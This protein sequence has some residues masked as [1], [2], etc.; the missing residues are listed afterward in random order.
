MKTLEAKK[1]SLIAIL[2]AA[3]M[4]FCVFAVAIPADNTIAAD[5]ETSEDE[6]SGITID[7][8][9]LDM[10]KLTGLYAVS[11]IET[12]LESYSYDTEEDKV[13][14][15]DADTDVSDIVSTIASENAE[16]LV[17]RNGVKVTFDVDDDEA[18]TEHNTIEIGT[19]VIENGATF[20]ASAL[21]SGTGDLGNLGIIKTK[22]VAIDGVVIAHLDSLMI[23]KTV[24]IST[25][26]DAT[27]A[28]RL[29]ITF[30]VPDQDGGLTFSSTVTGET[31]ADA[32]E[33]NLTI[34]GE[35]DHDAVD[36]AAEYNVTF[37]TTKTYADT[38]GNLTLSTLKGVVKQDAESAVGDYNISLKIAD[39]DGAVRTGNDP[40]PPE[41]S[42]TGE[43]PSAAEGETPVEPAPEYSA[44]FT[45]AGV[46]LT[47]ENTNGTDNARACEIQYQIDKY[48]YADTDEEN[49]ASVDVTFNGL[50]MNLKANQD[51]FEN[52]SA[53]FDRLVG[54]ATDEDGSNLLHA[55][56]FLIKFTDVNIR[57][58][59]GF[60]NAIVEII[61]TKKI[62]KDNV[63]TIAKN[64]VGFGMEFNAEYFDYESP[65]PSATTTTE[66]ETESTKAVLNDFSFKAAVDDKGIL[67]FGPVTDKTYVAKSAQIT[68]D[69]GAITYEVSA[70]YVG[71]SLANVNVADVLNYIVTNDIDSEEDGLGGVIS[72]IMTKKVLNGATISLSCDNFVIGFTQTTE[73]GI[74]EVKVQ[75][76]DL[77][78]ALDLSKFVFTFN[79]TAMEIDAFVSE[80][81]VTDKTVIGDKTNRSALNLLKVDFKIGFEPQGIEEFAKLIQKSA[82][83]EFGFSDVLEYYRT[84]LSTEN[85][86][87]WSSEPFTFTDLEYTIKNKGSDEDYFTDISVMISGPDETTDEQSGSDIVFSMSHD[88]E[89][90]ALSAEFKNNSELTYTAF[91]AN[92]LEPVIN[93]TEIKNFNITGLDKTSLDDGSKV[94]SFDIVSLLAA[95]PETEEIDSHAYFVSLKTVSPQLSVKD[96]NEITEE[97]IPLWKTAIAAD[98]EQY[99]MVEGFH[100]DLKTKTIEDEGDIIYA[101]V[102]ITYGHFDKNLC[103]TYKLT[104]AEKKTL[105][106]DTV[107]DEDQIVA[108][109]T[110]DESGNIIVYTDRQEHEGDCVS[111]IL[112]AGILKNMPGTPAKCTETGIL[113]HKYCSECEKNYLNGEEVTDEQ[114]VIPALGHDTEPVKTEAKAATCT[115][116]GNVEYYTCTKCQKNF[117][118]KACTTAIDDVVIP[119]LGHTVV[120]DAAEPATKNSEG[121]T[122]GTHCSV[123]G[124]VLIAPEKIEKLP[125]EAT[126]TIINT[127]D[128]SVEIKKTNINDIVND[129]LILEV[130]NDDVSAELSVKILKYLMKTYDGDFQ[131]GIEKLTDNTKIENE[132]IK[133]ALKDCNTIISI[134]LF[135]N[136]VEEHKLG[137]NATINL[138]YILP[139][140]KK[141]SDL[142]I[143]YADDDGNL[144]K[145]DNTIYKNNTITF[146]TDHFSYY[147]VMFD[148]SEDSDGFSIAEWVG[149]AIVIVLALAILV[150][151]MRS[152][153][154]KN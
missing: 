16:I 63:G 112:K 68:A 102:S 89:T 125:S 106:P 154:K 101:P 135:M 1:T 28:G 58:D 90:N 82:S 110:A 62:T 66:S 11:S 120:I 108:V 136:N 27:T 45:A 147:A 4:V 12:P 20:D 99:F 43:A 14:I 91:V 77:E 47:M 71:L 134:N 79:E 37:D 128:G 88:K 107:S 78:K 132:K 5:S 149:L 146:E 113:A 104:G 118:D 94:V 116:E 86:I 49:N 9:R 119:A 105:I 10:Q 25:V 24:T 17:I 137:S 98:P 152:A 21:D 122:A 76:G 65:A 53:S 111:F 56:N 74:K 87:S 140:D 46:Y 31:D 39:L 26:S 109:F 33:W 22:K 150:T 23:R 124:T 15:I 54:T 70:K 103:I 51:K 69:T 41:G 57:G 115:E 7:F 32:T 34:G 133:E 96:I 67:S 93:S 59:F 148:E 95:G 48:N 97:E 84:V 145:I 18:K 129:K 40:V 126:K 151:G 81:N 52:I 35:Y 80:L 142:Y 19:L 6:D 29:N 64:L 123:C 61:K 2:A 138:N 73:N 3:M 153:G 72:D 42:E 75:I 117:S 131:L 38:F 36:H 130:D 50:T 85:A 141:A 8:S 144:N 127:F 13:L 139:T 100:G 30:D 44:K 60:A 114:L 121:W 143:V 83:S 92:G 55:T